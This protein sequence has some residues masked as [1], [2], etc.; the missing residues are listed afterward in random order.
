MTRCPF[1]R[2]YSAICAEVTL[3]ER[4]VLISSFHNTYLDELIVE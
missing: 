1:F 3:N 2:T 4:F